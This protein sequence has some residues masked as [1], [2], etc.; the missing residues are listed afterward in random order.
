MYNI[1]ISDFVLKKIPS[2]LRVKSEQDR[3][4]FQLWLVASV[5]LTYVFKYLQT[6]H[7]LKL[8]EQS[9]SEMEKKKLY[10]FVTACTMLNYFS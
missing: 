5:A 7:Q 1:R 10:A 9:Y 8:Q 2:H 4:Q 6:L 3:P